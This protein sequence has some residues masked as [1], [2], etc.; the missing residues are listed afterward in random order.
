MERAD[1]QKLRN[2]VALSLAKSEGG[3][4]PATALRSELDSLDIPLVVDL[5]GTL[6]LTDTLFESVIALIKQKPW[7][8]IWLIG[9]L[10]RGRAVLKAKIA[11][12]VE[13]SAES[14]PYRPDL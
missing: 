12:H 10:L 14:L 5:D 9:W 6:V 8:V 2:E 11:E 1:H 13:I 4:E 3:A 7:S